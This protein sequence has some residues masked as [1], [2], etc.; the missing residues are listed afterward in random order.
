ML[1]CCTLANLRSM[2]H[3]PPPPEPARCPELPDGYITERLHVGELHGACTA[4]AANWSAT[5]HDAAALSRLYAR[6]AP[7]TVETDADLDV[8][9]LFVP[10]PRSAPHQVKALVADLPLSAQRAVL[11]RCTQANVQDAHA[12]ASASLH[13]VRDAKR[14]RV[15][16]QQRRPLAIDN[17][18]SAAPAAARQPDSGPGAVGAPLALPPPD[19]P[20][21]A[22]AGA[23]ELDGQAP[24]GDIAGHSSMNRP[25]TQDVPLITLSGDAGVLNV[26]GSSGEGGGQLAVLPAPPAG[27]GAAAAAVAA[28]SVL[29]TS[30]ADA[31]GLSGE[32]LVTVDVYQAQCSHRVSQV[33]NGVLLTIP[34]LNC[35][36]VVSIMRT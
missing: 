35:N 5:L 25:P 8:W 6:S 33:R 19:A 10:H 4:A 1:C 13:S 16:Y 34:L 32:L 20:A 11:E 24:A 17:G 2:A 15:V 7:S 14:R 30:E 28:H 18:G 9:H 3:Q 27:A 36:P 29:A 31:E 12:V 23:A 26:P 22:Q 21:A